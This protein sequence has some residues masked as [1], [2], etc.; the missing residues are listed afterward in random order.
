MLSIVEARIINYF[1]S[2]KLSKIQGER[3]S[4]PCFTPSCIWRGIQ[5]LVVSGPLAGKVSSTGLSFER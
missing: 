1:T 5:D 3:L 2:V 4:G